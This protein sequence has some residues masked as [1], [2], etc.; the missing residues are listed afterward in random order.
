MAPPIVDPKDPLPLVLIVLSAVTGLVDAVSVLGLGQ[1]FVANMTGN[2]VFLGFAVGGAP[3]FEVPRYVAALV[4]F[5]VGAL[6]G[7]W[8]AN[9]FAQSTR[10][11]WLLT[12]AAVETAL[13]WVA[14]V[15]AI[16]YAPGS[17]SP[18][19]WLFTLI[20]LTAV[21]M[22]LRN[23]TVRRLKVPDLTTTVLTL[24]LTGLAADSSLSGG[25][26]RNWRRRVAAVLATFMGAVIGAVLVRTSGLVVPLAVTG[27][28]VLVATLAYSLHPASR[29]RAAEPDGP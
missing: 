1:V 3:G 23:A 17:L 6:A 8:V 20:G 16:R 21:A 10:R 2:T 5:L 28:V 22:G 19:S 9:A 14:A 7:G 11:R 13:F 12:V 27:A 24:T 29:A 26:N 15:V 4:A 25:E 18:A